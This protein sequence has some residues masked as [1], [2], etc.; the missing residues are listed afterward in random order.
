MAGLEI[1]NG[2]FNIIVR[3]NGKRFVRSLKTENETVA[4]TK[5]LRIEETLKLIESGRLDVPVNADFMTFLLSDG[6]L[7]AKPKPQNQ[8][9]INELFDRVFATLPAENLEPTT[10]RVMQIHRRHLERN[11]GLRM[12]VQTIKLVDLQSYVTERAKAKTRNGTVTGTTIKK[13]L[14][15]LRTVW[16]WAV[17]RGL[18]CGEFPS[19]GLRLPKAK[20]PPIFKTWQ[21]IE[22]QQKLS[23]SANLWDS[24][25]LT[26]E[27]IESLLDHVKAAASLP[28]VYPMFCMAA[29]T[30]A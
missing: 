6:K 8:L 21:E 18:L 9:R 16:R 29:Y 12:V 17:D 24:L 23:T 15:T 3:F 19:R 11:L 25:Y 28:F 20:E 26:M 27:E 1:R 14:D 13:E 4:V 5:K 10:V 22:T 2:R 30:G 7:V